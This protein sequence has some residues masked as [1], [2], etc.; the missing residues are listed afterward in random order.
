[1]TTTTGKPAVCK[2]AT[3][4]ISKPPVAPQS[5]QFDNQLAKGLR[6]IGTTELIVTL[7][8][9]YFQQAF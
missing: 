1:L 2:A 4:G 6:F 5:D 3:T 7:V 9:G 8:R